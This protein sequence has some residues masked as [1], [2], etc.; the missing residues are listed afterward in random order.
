MPKTVRDLQ[1][2]DF[3]RLTV[4]GKVSPTA[5]GPSWLCQ[6]QCGMQAILCEVV[7]AEERVRSCGCDRTSRWLR[8]GWDLTGRLFGQWLVLAEGHNKPKNHGLWWLCRCQCG[9]RKAIAGS[10]LRA[11]KTTQCITCKNRSRITLQPN[12]WYNDWF[13]IERGGLTPKGEILWRCRCVCG[14]EHTVVGSKISRG[15]SSGCRCRKERLLDRQF[16]RWHVLDFA[17]VEGTGMT[18]Y[19]CQCTCASRTIRT[20]RAQDLLRGNSQSCG[21]LVKEMAR[22]KLQKIHVKKNLDKLFHWTMGVMQNAVEKGV[23]AAEGASV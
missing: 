7:L 11:G 17:E 13:I 19:R 10:A 20:V 3:G 12:R 14:K 4:L 1:F 18:Y 5:H 15:R 6:C 8:Q 2:Q 23:C 22:E 9:K 16:G 21:C